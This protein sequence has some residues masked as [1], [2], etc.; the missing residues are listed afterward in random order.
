MKYREISNTNLKV[1]VIG[2]GALHFGTFLTQKESRNIV[3]HALDAGINFIDTSPLYGQGQ[4]ESIVKNAV[5]SR[6]KDV[7]I[8]T[9]AGLEAVIRSDGTFGVEVPLISKEYLRKSV[10]D[11]LRALGTDYIDL[12]QLHA[13]DHQTPFEETIGCLEQ[14]VQE[15]KLRFIGCSNYNA[16]QLK[17]ATSVITRNDFISLATAQ[18]HYNLL[19]RR[20]Q[21]ELLQICRSNRISIICNRALAR[22]ILTGKYK[23]GKPLP[24]GC[25]AAVSYRIKRCLSKKTLNLVEALKK[26]SSEY[27]RTVTELAIAW[28]LS[29]NDVS[30]VLVGVRDILQLDICLQSVGWTLQKEDMLIVDEIIERM[31]LKNQVDSFPE[32]FLEK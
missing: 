30:T 6:R 11:S 28:L 12:F 8:A 17:T 27:S 1:S 24:Y 32:N 29:Y 19:E 25:R 14:L 5:N 7:F 26:F 4:S 18:C 16:A 22:G 13:F 20:A 10:E 31:G 3:H 2:L 9:K 21:H 15:G 23:H